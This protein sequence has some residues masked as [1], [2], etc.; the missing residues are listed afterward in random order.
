MEEEITKKI[1]IVGA[2][3]AGLSAAVNAKKKG[4]SIGVFESTSFAGGR[5]RSFPDNRMGI[6]IDNGN[7]IV[8]SA[9]EN[10]YELC[11]L[12]NSQNTIKKLN[13]SFNF[14]DI[15]KKKFWSMDLTNKEVIK[16]IFN[17]NKRIPGSTIKDYI[18]FLK[19]LVVNKNDKVFNLTSKSNIYKS[20]WEPFTLGIMNTS[21][22]EA[23]A[24]I[25][26]NVLKKTLFRGEKFCHIYQPKINWNKTLIEPSLNFLNNKE[27]RVN[28]NFTLKK[29]IVEK[30]RITSLIFNKKVCK[31]NPEDHV[32]F[33][34]PLT[35]FANFF[36]EYQIPSE[37]N[38]ILNIHYKLP[39][40]ILNLFKKEIIG[41]INSFS[42]WIFVKDRHISVTISD[43][44][45]LQQIP[46]DEIAKLV[47]TEICIFLGKQI[48]LK[49]FRVIKEKKA[50]YAQ[51]PENNFLIKNISK[52]PTN[53]SLAGD[54]TQTDLPCTIEG[55]IL[56][57]KKAVELLEF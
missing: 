26:S 13:P 19:F 28:F 27:T 21:P 24:K 11:K 7:H 2:G 42:H 36:P 12:I 33:A 31:I 15:E 39:K 35:S 54:W 3:L 1:Y 46:S 22:E 9:N 43:A 30:K 23:S 4:F 57:G 32:I 40:S 48:L 37:F 18:T 50:T 17:K 49:E 16:L 56:S 6:E 5:C 25:L 34:L 44:N 29:I 55:S 14:F 53:L 45:N 51:S 38:T 41:L 47:W 10:F 20:F 52:L 8:L